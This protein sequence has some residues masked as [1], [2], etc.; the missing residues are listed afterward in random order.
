MKE[1]DR[2]VLELRQKTLALGDVLSP[3]VQFSWRI[4][5]AKD[6]NKGEDYGDILA[7]LY[8]QFLILED[9]LVEMREQLPRMERAYNENQKFVAGRMGE[10][11][12]DEK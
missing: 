3:I 11:V 10:E 6:R 8:E 1:R 5:K 4:K 12:E 7:Q 9:F 2:E